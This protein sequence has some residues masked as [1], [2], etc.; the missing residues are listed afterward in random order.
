MDERLL[1]AFLASC[2]LMVSPAQTNEPANTKSSS[3]REPITVERE[4]SLKLLMANFRKLLREGKY[5]EAEICARMMVELDPDNPASFA[6]L[7]TAKNMRNRSSPNDA[8]PA[9]K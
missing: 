8:R 1:A 3:W 9:S 2:L 6:A 4:N 5:Q 7:Y